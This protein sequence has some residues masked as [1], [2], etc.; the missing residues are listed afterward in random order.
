MKPSFTL[1]Y[2]LG[3]T[4]EM[5]PTEASGKQDVLVD[6]SDTPVKTLDYLAQR[7]AAALQGQVYNPELGFALVGN[8]G[9][10]DKYPYNP[11][12]GSFSPRVAAAWNPHF[13]EGFLGHVF[14]HDDTVIRGG[15]GRVYGRLN[16]VDLVLVPLLGIGLIQPV[17][18]KQALSTGAC[19]PVNPD[20]T[21]AFRIGTDGQTA[22]L[23]A[24]SATLPQPVYPGF[25]NAEGATAEGLDPNFRP[26]VSDTFNL[27]IQRRISRSQTLEVGY[28]GRLIHHEYQPVN[29][30]AVPYMMVQGGQSFQ[31][32]YA[33]LETAIGCT[34]SMGACMASVA[35]NTITPQPFFEA[36][37]AGTGYCTG[38]ASCTAAVLS[39][40]FSNL[41]GQYVWSI[42]SDLDNGGFNFPRSMQNTPIPGSTYGGQ[43]S[44]GLAL[45]AS[46]GYGNY[47]GGFITLVT[48]SWHGLLMHNNFTYSKA[49]GT[50]AEVQATS[51]YTPNDPFDLRKM[52][53]VQ[54]FNRKFVFNSYL[55]YDEPFFKGQ[56]GLLGRVAGGWSLAPIFTSGSGEPLWC[57]SVTDGQSFG[58]ADAA[59][60]FDNEQC[61]FTSKYTGGVHSH[62]G[63]SGGNDPYGNAVGT[64][65][66]GG[67]PVNM[68]KDPVAVWN[69]VRAPILGIDTKDSGL[70]P[71]NG[72]PYWNVDLSLQKNVKVYER[73]T[74]TFSM[75]FTNVFNHNVLED[76]QLQL[77]NP[78]T[79][80]VQNTQLNN[81]RNMEFGARVSF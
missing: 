60:Y 67:Q 74:L 68:F 24:A 11:F 48:Q 71:L 39:N 6:D 51:E 17:Q 2:G 29:L 3:W 65:G 14:G 34:K 7:K 58:G 38:F 28:I 23:P 41:Q 63:V 36:A 16:G 73:A 55:V 72:T 76:Q 78:S 61:V 27:T 12:Y 75:I 37:L 59:N 44:S 18:C 35:P 32:A 42:W 31:N 25:N 52:Y 15:Y 1:T 26:N 45:N 56:Q 22:P 79:F 69:M 21:T 4:L 81:P 53:G 66:F 30:N 50:G 49:L 64:S 33:A 5:P 80:G 70:G 20:A 9:A 43:A 57:N 47:N 77:S 54:P 46:I 8:V 10:G 40:E 19:G 62:Y 13:G